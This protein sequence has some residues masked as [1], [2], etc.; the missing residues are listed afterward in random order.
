MWSLISYGI[1][2]NT[3]RG[4]LGAGILTYVV[5]DL[6]WYCSKYGPRPA[7]GRPDYA[8]SAKRTATGRQ[9]SRRSLIVGAALRVA[10]MAAAA[11]AVPVTHRHTH[12]HTLPS[13][14][15]HVRRLQPMGGPTCVSSTCAT[16][17]QAVPA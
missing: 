17:H 8:P 2:V 3:G 9:R 10:A 1:I 11:A 15:A 7:G 12:S 6:L 4:R 16:L 5:A 14:S 13:A